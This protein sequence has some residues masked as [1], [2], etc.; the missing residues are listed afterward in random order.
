MIYITG[1]THGN[2]YKWVEQI[3]PVLSSGDMIIVNGD[4]GIGFWNGRYW[5]E[6]A[7]FDFISEQEYTVL[8]V[9]GNHENFDKLNSYPVEM[10]NSGKVHKIRHNLMHLM[11]GEVYCIDGIT[12]FAFGGGYSIDKYRRQENISWWPQEMPS[13]EEYRN[14]EQN[15]K[16]VN[17]QVDYIITHTAPSESVY[18]LSTIRRLGIKNDVSEERPLTAFLDDIQRRVSYRHWYFGHF[19]VDAELWRNQ[20][21]MLNTVRELESGKAV[22]QRDSYVT[23]QTGLRTCCADREKM[24][25]VGKKPIAVGDFNGFLP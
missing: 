8:F 12:I 21:A 25:Q 4:F 7:F 17:D 10:W 14:A 9:D 2:Q 22:Y 19:H 13:E 16:K 11:R 3:E 1:D 5:S 15:L 24:I 20:T 6:E 18:Y 23:V